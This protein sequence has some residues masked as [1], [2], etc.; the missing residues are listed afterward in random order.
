MSCKRCD[1]LGRTCL[2][3][4]VSNILDDLSPVRKLDKDFDFA[5][6]MLLPPKHHNC[7]CSKSIDKPSIRK[8]ASGAWRDVDDNK[9]DYEAC[10]SPIV[11]HS[12]AA[13]IHSHRKQPDGTMRP[14]DNWQK[15]IDKSEY[16][17]SLCRHVQDLRMLH[18]GYEVLDEKDGHSITIEEACNGIRFNNQ[19]YLFEELKDI[20]TINRGAKK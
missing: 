2:A 20:K 7:H 4:K 1:E 3:C 16:L 10:I 19:G 6:G 17:K 12:Y 15:G 9:L 18:D 13:F 8:F 14:D 11:D 5:N